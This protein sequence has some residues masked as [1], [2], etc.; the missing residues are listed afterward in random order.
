MIRTKR[1]LKKELNKKIIYMYIKIERATPSKGGED[2]EE[3]CSHAMD[4]Q[5]K[6]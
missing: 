4:G 6:T 2:N 1:I 5:Q 3:K